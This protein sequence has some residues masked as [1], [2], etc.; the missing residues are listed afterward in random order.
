VQQS[1]R[2][3][4]IPQF[5][6]KL[7]TGKDGKLC[8]FSRPHKELVSRRKAPKAVGFDYDLYSLPG[9]IPEHV[10]F[11]ED[12][13][14]ADRDQR[15][16]NALQ[17]ILCRDWKNFSCVHREAF[18]RFLVSLHHRTPERVQHIRRELAKLTQQLI[19][20]IREEIKTG[21]RPP[22]P[23]DID[24]NNYAAA[25]VART[26][27]FRWGES[28]M[29]LVDSQMIGPAIFNMRW[30]FKPLPQAE[31]CLVLGDHPLI[32]SNGFAHAEGHIALP[33]GP[34]LLFLATNNEATERHILRR[35][36]QRIVRDANR[37]TLRHAK[38]FVYA[39]DNQQEKFVDRRLGKG[40]DDKRS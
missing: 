40:T 28:L 30:A 9:A 10:T 16:C 21:A 13:F 6:S 32:R 35:P 15:A 37:E 22:F 19:E 31:R 17:V 14:F 36:D 34:R 25:L 18:T 3:H 27:Q 8:E 11:L 39:T 1:R 29:A 20:D 12:R 26:D 2:H 33:L 7:W 5:L 24:F 38:R 4:F 23:S